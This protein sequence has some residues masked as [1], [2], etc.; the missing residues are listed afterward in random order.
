MLKILNDEFDI[1][2]VLSSG[3]SSAAVNA[4]AGATYGPSPPPET[5]PEVAGSEIFLTL[6]AQGLAGWEICSVLKN[7]LPDDIQT[8]I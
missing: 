5:L 7:M 4:S 3:P 2:Y 8:L 6:D 1:K